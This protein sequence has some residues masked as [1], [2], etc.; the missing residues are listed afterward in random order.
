[1]YYLV[2]ASKTKSKLDCNPLVGDLTCPM[3]EFYRA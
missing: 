3:V 2:M 1:M